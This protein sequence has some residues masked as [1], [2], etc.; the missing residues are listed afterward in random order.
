MS[1]AGRSR[2]VSLREV[3]RSFD[4]GESRIAALRGIT[5]DIEPGEFVAIT[6]P[7]GSGKSSCASILGCLDRPTT[8]SCRIQGHETTQLDAHGLARVRRQLIGF[9]FQ[10]FQLL[11]QV[12][13]VGNVALP[14]AYRGVSRLERERLSCRALEAVGLG[15]RMQHLPS[16]LSG[17][18]QQRVAIARAIVSRPRLIIADEPTAALDATTAREIMGLLRELNRV[19]SVT[20]VIVTHDPG[21]A[22]A[23]DRT[24]HIDNGVV[25]ASGGEDGASA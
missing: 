6:G 10:G 20:L 15:D 3:T 25:A 22:A 1:D 17:G 18:Q 5:L 21:V 19:R 9:V 2:F 13:A 8:G 12:N 14:L 11:S 16:E 7:S 4:T 23:A 24:L